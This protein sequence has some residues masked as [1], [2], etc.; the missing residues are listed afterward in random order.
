MTG[1]KWLVVIGGIAL[2]MLINWYFFFAEHAV[3]PTESPKGS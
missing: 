3:T 2:V 1:T